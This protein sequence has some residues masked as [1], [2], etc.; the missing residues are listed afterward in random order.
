MSNRAI[1]SSSQRTRHRRPKTPQHKI[2]RHLHPVRRREVRPEHDPVR[3]R[4][5]LALHRHLAVVR[6]E[7]PS[8]RRGAA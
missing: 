3:V 4:E 8:G 2:A 1:P 6:P 5:R 7:N